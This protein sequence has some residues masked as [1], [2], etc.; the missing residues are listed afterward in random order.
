MDEGDSRY[1]VWHFVAQ[2][3]FMNGLDLVL[4]DT[5]FFWLEEARF[6]ELWTSLQAYGGV[7]EGRLPTLL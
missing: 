6:R 5:R 3:D 7:E 1:F 4:A 2:T